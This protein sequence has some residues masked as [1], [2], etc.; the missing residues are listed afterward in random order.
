MHQ[1]SPHILIYS[2]VRDLRVFNFTYLFIYLLH[3]KKFIRNIFHGIRVCLVNGICVKV[4]N[5]NTR[6]NESDMRQL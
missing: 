3:L 6:L 4:F 2:C 5:V 1:I